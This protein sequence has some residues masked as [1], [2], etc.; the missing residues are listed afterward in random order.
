[1]Q[2]TDFVLLA[3]GEYSDYQTAAFK[4]LKPFTMREATVL[5]RK[6]RARVEPMLDRGPFTFIEWLCAKGY[7]EDADIIE[8][9]T[10]SYGEL[11]LDVKTLDFQFTP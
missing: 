11:R 5:F 4:V 1:M 10:G 6:D 2:R 9:H 7:V 3:S 8:V